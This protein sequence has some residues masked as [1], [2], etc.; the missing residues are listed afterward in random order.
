MKNN[1][2][3]I[4]LDLCEKSSKNGYNLA[5]KYQ[6]SL[7]QTLK[8]SEK[9]IQNTINKF[10]NSKYDS[11]KENNIL[12][13]QLLDIKNSFRKLSTNIKSD[14][15]NKK[16]TLSKF[17]ITLFGRT[18]AGK[19]T[20]MEILTNGDGKSIGLGSQ[21]TTR[22]IRKYMWN[23]LEITDVPGI[24]AF[25][26]QEDEDLA[27][28]S[29]KS[30]DLILFLITDD[31]PQPK[32]AECF[33]KIINLGKPIIS[34]INVKT[35]ITENTSIK[36][37]KYEIN[38]KFDTNRL[39]SIK[40][41][42]LSYSLKL[43]ED[44]SNIPFIYVH[45]K[46]AFLSQKLKKQS[47]ENSKILYEMSK[48]NF[49]KKKIIKV[50]KNNGE[51]YR[52][53]TFVDLVSKPIIDATD[54]LLNQS[55][56]NSTQGKVILNKKR[57]LET[58]E[59]K[60]NENSTKEIKSF[61]SNI[62]SQLNSEIVSFAEDYFENKNVNKAWEIVLK[63][64]KIEEKAQDLMKKFE[65]QCT[66]EIKEITRELENELKFSKSF[67]KSKKIK[68]NTII[69]EKKIWNW[70]A[71][72]V[73]SGFTI[74]SIIAFFLGSATSG[75]IGWV[76]LG[77]SAIGIL[78]NFL[79]ESRE[80]KENRARKKLEKHLQENVL[81]ICKNLEKQMN[82]NLNLLIQKR[83]FLLI[84]ELYKVNTIVFNLVDTQ[85]KLAWNLNSHLL[86]L[87][88]QLITEAIKLIGAGG[89][90][91]HIRSV[92]RIPGITSLIVLNNG[93]RIPK[94]EYKKLYLLINEKII[95]TFFS[96]NK[97]ILIS[98]VL[99]SSVNRSN[100]NIEEKIGVAHIKLK[101]SNISNK[102]KMAQQL[103]KILIQNI[104]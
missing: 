83:I 71:I 40:E 93:V 48:I 26:G 27:F 10:N 69:N 31:A 13:E 88:K 30:A 43:E 36:M 37:A 6:S 58:W 17:S 65:N 94:E 1:D 19:S 64:K 103:T 60:F 45:L 73:S 104:E 89:M 82:K 25:E 91:Y 5:N 101:N 11:S 44:W 50:V 68:T 102:I 46:S 38:K 52:L 24:G 23:N 97:K 16:D 100:I 87:N 20:L 95:Y 75:P 74:G 59:Q 72:V 42:F 18:M 28:E 15:E 81:N 4:I 56:V 79:F 41:Q 2:L 61:I 53:K 3:K 33:S 47:K 39:D 14:L 34:I 62:K 86:E 84:E 76:A 70:S 90:E 55:T 21:R 49:L 29:A 77:I 63:N 57:E 7:N 96:E 66:M 98:R 22:D 54:T 9:E 67:I 78:G 12:N 32:E 99:G 8:N 80:K 92:A 51:F 35:S 85:K